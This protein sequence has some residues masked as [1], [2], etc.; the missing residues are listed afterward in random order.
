MKRRIEIE[1][2]KWKENERRKVLLLRG[3]RQVGKTFSVRALGNKFEHFLEVNFE[4]E[5]PV[6]TFFKGSL[7]PVALR[8]KLSAY[9]G[10]PI[11]PGKTLLFFDEIQACS[12]ALR[13]LRFFYEK[14]PELHVIAAGSLLEF[15]LAELPSFGVGR[16]T[17]LFMRPLSF[18]EF[19]TATGCDALNSVI[20]KAD[21]VNVV[22]PVIHEKILEKIRIY[23]ILGGMPEVVDAYC[24]GKDVRECLALIDDL[25]ATIRDDFAKY[26]KRSPVIKLQETFN[27]IPLQTGNKFKYSNVSNLGSTQGYKDSLELLVNAG[28]AYKVY[29]S[30]AR[31]IP[32]GGQ[33]E[34]KKFKVILFDIGIHQRILG[35]D[36]SRHFVKSHAQLINEGKIS[37]AFVGLELIS[38]GSVNLH[39]QLFY[40]HREARAGNAEVDY[41]IQKNGDIFPIEV[42]AG[43]KGQM[44]SMFIFLNERN[45]DW[46]YR[47]SQENFSRYDKIRTI[48]IYA[49][50]RVL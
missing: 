13:S 37:E 44:Q 17:S 5:E 32:L 12:G 22:D 33:M 39:P 27:S 2:N 47:I 10:V 18:M 48:P 46:G 19:L 41:L 42:K 24:S 4:E 49:V 11:I 25:L 29:H 28:L 15:A 36:L 45:L 34:T 9:F 43:T 3:A 1:L 30:S 40:W 16:I 8:E 26:K 14:M 21:H 38:H 6:K 35:L 31:G 23:F 7:N 50:N 20:L